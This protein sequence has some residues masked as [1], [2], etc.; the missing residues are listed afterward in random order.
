MR[1]LC[2]LFAALGLSVASRVGRCQEVITLIPF[3][4][5]YG[6]CGA[7][8]INGYVGNSVT[9]I[10]RLEWAWDDDTAKDSWF[11]AGH[12][13]L[14]NGN[15]AVKVTAYS[16]SG[17]TK[18]VTVPLAITNAPQTNASVSLV[19]APPEYGACGAVMFEGSLAVA[20]GTLDRVQWNWGDGTTSESG[21]PTL[22]TYKSNGVYSVRA[23]AV[24][25]ACGARTITN[26]V[27]VTNVCSQSPNINLGLTMPDYGG[28]GTVSING[29][30]GTSRGSITRLLWNW[31][32]GTTSETWFTGRHNY[33]SNRCYLVQVT[34]YSNLGE[35][36]TESVVANVT[37][38]LP[39][40]ENTFRVLPP[41]VYLKAG[42]T[43][44][45]L[46][47][48]LRTRDGLPIP[49]ANSAVTFLSSKPNLVHV[50]SDGNVVSTG[51]GAAQIEVGIPG[52]PRKVMVDV[53]A[54]EIRLEPPILLLATSPLLEA[55]VNLNAFNADASAMS[56]AGRQVVFT[57][58]N[59]VASVSPEGNVTPL[60]PPG[61]FWESPYI[62]AT[63]DG[64]PA[65]NA[66][67]IRV[68]SS[69]LNLT[70]HNYEGEFTTLRVAE[71]V[72]Q[73]PYGSLMT[74]LQVVQ[75]VDALYRLAHRLTGGKPGRGARQY[76]ALDPGLDSNGH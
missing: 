66:C 14:A 36:R 69:N 22:H 41:V 56:L 52:Q 1:N 11:P 55:Q 12:S 44:E 30:V 7:V 21:F 65:D 53:F 63:L 34:A 37:T 24:S 58:G 59:T 45:M 17:L 18:T 74:Q 6:Q 27:V 75:V 8:S 60:R 13:Y 29:Y 47:I 33:P 57:G 25:T 46:S 5:E 42:K 61:S 38:I 54:G 62:N 68:T 50:G 71:R 31:A 64:M 15:Y 43:N 23:T 49:V 28:C 32:D 70:M 2:W 35:T 10:T 72:G 19:C 40:C 73:Y 20:T 48:D 9:N 39:G 16:A 67:F 51:L 3:T 76:L 4:P 26:E